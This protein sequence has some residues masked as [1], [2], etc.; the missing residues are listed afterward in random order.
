MQQ[1]AAQIE[2]VSA[3]RIAAEL[4][5]M[6]AHENRA[7]ALELLVRTNLLIAILPDVGSSYQDLDDDALVAALAAQQALHDSSFVV[8]MALLL[9]PVVAT[10]QF[11][12]WWLDRG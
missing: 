9:L 7:L 12:S 1:S 4:Q 10:A 11:N 2:V 3:E 5:R 8:S 6:L